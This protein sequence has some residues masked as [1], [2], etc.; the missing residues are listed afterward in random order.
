MASRHTLTDMLTEDEK[1]AIRRG[2]GV[3]LSTDVPPTDPPAST[4]A[5]AISHNRTN[6][7]S[8]IDPPIRVNRGYK[9]REDLIRRCKRLAVD[10]GRPLYEVM[11]AALEEYLGRHP[12]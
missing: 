9:L 2:R 11:E 3:Q 7:Q 12:T 6:A 4:P 10:R 8:H 1:P 5:S